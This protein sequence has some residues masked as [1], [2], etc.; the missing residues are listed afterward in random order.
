[1][2]LPGSQRQL[3]KELAQRSRQGPADRTEF[4]VAGGFSGSEVIFEGGAEAPNLTEVSFDSEA[5]KLTD[6]FMPDFEG[7]VEVGFVRA[8]RTSAG[9][10]R[11][12]VTHA[13]FDYVAKN[14]RPLAG[15]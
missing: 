13:G 14:L 5:P 12:S 7:L 2:S 3:L 4:V 6:V 1:M 11:A 9:E 10:L 8:R 15:G